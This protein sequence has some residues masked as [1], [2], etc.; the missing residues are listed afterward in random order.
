MS[1]VALLVLDAA[2]DVAELEHGERDHDQHQDDGLGGRAA[3]VEAF[4]HL[5]PCAPDILSY[6]LTSWALRQSPA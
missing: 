5:L 4:S 6:A 2:L 1:L 3:E